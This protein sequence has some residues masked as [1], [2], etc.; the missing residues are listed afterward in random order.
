LSKQD[1]KARKARKKKERAKR[2]VLARRQK[3]RDEARVKKEIEL[4]K[5]ETEEK[6]EPY[7][8]EK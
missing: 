1:L 2:R 4:I 5:L 6:I 8:K 3:I 7:R